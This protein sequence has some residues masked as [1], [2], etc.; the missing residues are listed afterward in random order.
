MPAYVIVTMAI[1]DPATYKKYTDRT[2][3]IVKRHGG[4]FLTRGDEVFT[5]EG[6]PF[7]DRMVILEFPSKA[8]VDAWRNDPDYVEACQFR[9]ASST[10][11][12]IVQES[13]GNTEDP[14]PRL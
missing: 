7:T 14:D 3:P 13:S 12:M 6:A 11:R 4:R 8:H 5:A 10:A 2:P 9:Y 1:H